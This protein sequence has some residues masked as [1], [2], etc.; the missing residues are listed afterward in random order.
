MQPGA[1]LPRHGVATR[2]GVQTT[3]GGMSPARTR[4]RHIGPNPLTVPDRSFVVSSNSC[5]DHNG[6]TSKTTDDAH[7]YD[8]AQGVELDGNVYKHKC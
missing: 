2:H 3:M 8:K 7:A 6:L 4:V 5:C 1:R